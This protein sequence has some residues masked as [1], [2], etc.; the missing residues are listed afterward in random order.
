MAC[1]KP[2]AQSLTMEPPSE[3][4]VRPQQEPASTITGGG[5]GTALSAAAFAHRPSVRASTTVTTNIGPATT[6][7]FSDVGSV[8]YTT[9]DRQMFT[10]SPPVQPEVDE[11]RH[12]DVIHA[13]ALAMARRMYSPREDP[14]TIATAADRPRT[15]LP[16]SDAVVDGTS[17]DASTVPTSPVTAIYGSNL[18]EAAYRL[19][20]DRLAKLQGELDAQRRMSGSPRANLQK[21]F[22]SFYYYD[23]A[24]DPLLSPDQQQRQQQNPRR[25]S[26]KGKF[27]SNQLRQQQEEQ[28]QRRRAVSDGALAEEGRRKKEALLA[29]AQRNVMQQ[30]KE[31]DRNVQQQKQQQPSPERAKDEWSKRALALAQARVAAANAQTGDAAGKVD[32]GGGMLV[33][34]AEVDRIAFQRVKPVLD[35]IHEQAAKEKERREEEERMK[36]VEKRRELEVKE[37]FKQLKG[38]LNV[39][40]PLEEDGLKLTVGVNSPAKAG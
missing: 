16:F 19:A 38:K 1:M 40:F 9:L 32:V 8:P 23:L 11:K 21:Y 7:P 2:R 36:E 30:M 33:D 15:I 12:S 24:D 26:L 4:K 14:A 35:E 28:Q 31:I 29:V 18:Q 17:D 10:S 34:R 25:W 3:Q 22:H 27:S 20:Q 5:G 13:S 6:A 37:T 39:D